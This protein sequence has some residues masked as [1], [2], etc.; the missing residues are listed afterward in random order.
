MTARRRPRSH[1]SEYLYST[2]EGSPGAELQA[3]SH[4]DVHHRYRM[5]GTIGQSRLWP[6]KMCVSV[7]VQLRHLK[8]VAEDELGPGTVVGT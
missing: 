7:A 4:M 3:A 8:L 5:T 6:S 1:G 2:G